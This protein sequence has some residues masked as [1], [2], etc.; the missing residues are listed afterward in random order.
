M[1]A[2]GRGSWELLVKRIGSYFMN[3]SCIPTRVHEHIKDYRK[4][5][6]RWV[7]LMPILQKKR[8]KMRSEA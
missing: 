5:L 8:K 3:A 4:I 7:T 2:S 6:L 1:G